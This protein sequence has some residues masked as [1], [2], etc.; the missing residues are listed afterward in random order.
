VGSVD[1]YG[2]LGDVIIAALN[3][4]FSACGGL[5]LAFLLHL[6]AMKLVK[7]SSAMG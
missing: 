7:F 3:L 2:D 5:I 4:S 6:L 1:T